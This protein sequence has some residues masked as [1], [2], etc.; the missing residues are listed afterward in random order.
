[1]QLNK[2]KEKILE[3]TSKFNE[4]Y[5]T[6]SEREKYLIIGGGITLI[7]LLAY[8][9]IYT[10]IIELIDE[11]KQAI[12]LAEREI[13]ALPFVIARY[14]K[15]RQRKA[16]NEK[17]Y[18]S[19]NM[20]EGAMT[21]LEDLLKNKAG[22]EASSFS[23]DPPQ[24]ATKITDEYEQQLFR[25]S[26]KTTDYVKLIEFL[27]ELTYGKKPMIISRLEIRKNEAADSL[28]ASIIVNSIKRIS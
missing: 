16:E 25:I 15:L 7:V 6:R 1:M 17:L 5:S 23:I 21:F 14:D 27:E 4:Y 2:I 24:P 28:Q 13:K 8:S 9:F 26:L 10:P 18:S 12:E 22:L 11:Q 19:M 3:A 20:P